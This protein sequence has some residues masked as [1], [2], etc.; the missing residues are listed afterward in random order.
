MFSRLIPKEEKFF[1]LLESAARNALKSTTAFKE[2]VHKWNPTSPYFKEVRKLETEGDLITHEVIDMLNRTFITPI[3][4]EDIHRLAGE[5]DDVCDILQALTD[6][7]ELYDLDQMAPTLIKMADLLEESGQNMAAA[8]TEF[9][10]FRKNSRVN[11]HCIEIK[12]IENEADE[13]LKHALAEM[14]RTKGKDPVWVIKWKEIYETIEFA[15]DKMSHIAN[16]VEGI[17]VK[18]A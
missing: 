2:L 1:E 6:R 12:R 4:R 16:T 10:H 15:H 13:L 14:F 17:L 9:P 11:D 18:N 7:M 8:I 3:D 5:I